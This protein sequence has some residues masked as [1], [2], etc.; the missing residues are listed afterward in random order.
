MG[1]MSTTASILPL[2]PLYLEMEGLNTSSNSRLRAMNLSRS[3]HPSGSTITWGE[4]G[5]QIA[6]EGEAARLVV[7]GEVEVEISTGRMYQT[8]HNCSPL[9]RRMGESVM[10]EMRTA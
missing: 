3:R 1:P 4:K 2:A 10:L 8:W 6:G 5:L 7:G 9:F